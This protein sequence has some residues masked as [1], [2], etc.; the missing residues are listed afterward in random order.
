MDYA[1]ILS[2]AWDYTKR[3][4]ALWLFGLLATCGTYHGGAG[5][6]NVNLSSHGHARLPQN[7]PPGIARWWAQMDLFLRHLSDTQNTLLIAAFVA[8]VLGLSLVVWVVGRYGKA[9]VLRGAFKAA[10]DGEPPTFGDLAREALN[11]A[12]RLLL[13]DLVVG[14]GFLLFMLLLPLWVISLSLV[15]GILTLGLG[16]V[17]LLILLLCL[18][19]P[20]VLLLK[21]YVHLVHLVLIAEPEVGI[22]AAFHLAWQRLL[23]RFGEWVI[24][25]LLLG[26]IGFLV[27]LVLSIP[28]LALIFGAV[29]AFQQGLAPIGLLFGGLLLLYALLAWGVSGGLETFRLSAW[30][31]TYR[32]LVPRPAIADAAPPP[33][34]PSP[35]SPPLEPGEPA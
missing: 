20:L 2:Q 34:M 5:G 29:I 8:F 28:A 6:S 33:P 24:M 7:L 19:L 16:V 32:E 22:F 26:L 10:A 11:F 31:L 4:K 1:R 30:A 12:A 18:L 25:G 17:V 23:E 15:F 3:F 9:G 13:A 27:G 14:A 35:D 21:L